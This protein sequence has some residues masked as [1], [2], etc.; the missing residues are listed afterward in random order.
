MHFPAT[1]I[2]RPSRWLVVPAGLLALIITTGCGSSNWSASQPA[3]TVSDVAARV[4]A[5]ATTPPPVLLFVGTGTTSGSVSAFKTI[6]GNL[7]LHYATATSSQLNSMSESTLR[8]Y[9][10]LL[11]PGGDAIT[12]SKNLTSTAINNVHNAIVNDGLHYL[13]ICAGAFFAGHSGVYH[14]LNLTPTGL[15]F[16]F[17]AD[18]FKG[19]HKESVEIRGGDGKT[20]DQYWENGPQLS[21][22]GNIVGKYPDGTPGTVENYSGKGWVIL[23]AFHPEATSSWRGGMS[24]STSVSVDNA[25]AQ[26]L[27]THALN[28]TSLAHF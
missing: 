28:G 21:G 9:K 25:Y 11:M 18:Y 13:G 14:Y 15:W 8:T 1:H 7:N 19:I 5:G 16:N 12:I 23:C 27:V 6:L 24:F 26:S 4:L 20:L 2:S 17:Y 3:P 10:L 22:W